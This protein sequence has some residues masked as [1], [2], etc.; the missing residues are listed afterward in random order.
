MGFVLFFFFFFQLP[1][2]H[3][4]ANAT[5]MTLTERFMHT[6]RVSGHPC[7]ASNRMQP[8]HSAKNDRSQNENHNAECNI[9]HIR[10]SSKNI[11][12]AACSIVFNRDG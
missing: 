6:T 9:N 3:H 7:M 2:H 12:K 4:Q 8:E 10:T 5:H 11:I 1:W